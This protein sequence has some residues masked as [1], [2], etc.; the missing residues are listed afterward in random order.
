[1]LRSTVSFDAMAA[2]FIAIGQGL[3]QFAITALRIAGA[4]QARITREGLPTIRRKF[5]PEV[6]AAAKRDYQ[7]G[8][9]TA[10]EIAERYGMVVKTVETRASRDGWRK[11]VTQAPPRC[12]RIQIPIGSMKPA[13]ANGRRSRIRPS[14][15][16]PA[17]GRPGC[18]RAGAAGK[19]R[20]GA[21]WLAS[22]AEATLNGIFA[23]VAAT[24]HD[25]R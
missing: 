6:W 8:D 9:F 11:T 23:I 21:E 14:A 10:G 20:A 15:S 22:R 19:T 18:S 4:A 7:E 2:A 12:S 16:L 24:E 1:V 5:S 13:P 25:L 17:N 3:Q